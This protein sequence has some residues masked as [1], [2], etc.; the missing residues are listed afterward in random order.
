MGAERP[1]YVNASVDK[2]GNLDAKLID[3]APASPTRL[4]G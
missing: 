4:W 1:I 3:D 2:D